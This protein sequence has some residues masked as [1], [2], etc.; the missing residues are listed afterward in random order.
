MVQRA[1]DT[2]KMSTGTAITAV[3]LIVAGAMSFAYLR[4]EVIHTKE[5]LEDLKRDSKD[6]RAKLERD[7][8]ANR[9]TIAAIQNLTTEYRQQLLNLNEKTT[10]IIYKL[11]E[12]EPVKD[13]KK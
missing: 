9:K 6:A 12:W 13:E 11:D 3:S 1:L 10:R 5:D 7:V 2:L 4:S 8:E